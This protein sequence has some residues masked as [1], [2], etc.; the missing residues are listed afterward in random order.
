MEYLDIFKDIPPMVLASLILAIIGVVRIYTAIIE[1]DYK[2][3]GKIAVAG[4]AGALFGAFAPLSF[5]VNWFTG[6]ILGFSSAGVI[7]SLSSVGSRSSVAVDKA[8]VIKTESVT[9]E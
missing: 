9:T 6:M 2:A 5:P 8:N 1:Q 7:F 3:A 4:L